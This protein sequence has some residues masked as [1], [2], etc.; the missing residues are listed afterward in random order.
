MIASGAGRVWLLRGVVAI[1]ALACTLSG[2]SAGA[3]AEAQGSKAG[4]ATLEQLE[5]ALLLTF[6]NYT[7]WPAGSL[8]P[9]SGPVTVGVVVD[10]PLWQAFEAVS[11]GRRAGGRPFASARLQWDSDVSNVHVLFLGRTMERRHVDAMLAKVQRRPVLTVSMLPEFAAAGGMIAL[12]S[13][14]GRVSFAVN[15]QAVALSG[16]RLSSFLLTHATTVSDP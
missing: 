16:L 15:S 9:G 8:P 4:T 10:N 6:I 12:K 7:V 5:A 13:S 14:G 11:K 1:C 2:L 3:R